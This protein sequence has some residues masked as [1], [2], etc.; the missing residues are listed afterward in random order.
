MKKSRKLVLYP[1]ITTQ[2]I[3]NENNLKKVNSNSNFEMLVL[4][5]Q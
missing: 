4:L 3:Q 2:N 1:W 5:E